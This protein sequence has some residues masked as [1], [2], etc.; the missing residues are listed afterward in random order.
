MRRKFVALQ[1]HKMMR[2]ESDKNAYY[3]QLEYQCGRDLSY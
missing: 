3:T 2:N 1:E